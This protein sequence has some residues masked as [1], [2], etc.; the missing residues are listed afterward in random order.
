MADSWRVV[1]GRKATSSVFTVHSKVSAS[2][3]HSR[4]RGT[5]ALVSVPRVSLR[6]DM[7][8]A[9]R[10]PG[11]SG[12]SSRRPDAVEAARSSKSYCRR[13]SPN[14][15]VAKVFAKVETHTTDVVVIGG[16]IG[17][18]CAGALCALYG[19]KVTVV[20][21]HS[22]AGGAAHSWKRNGYTFESGPSLYSG[23]SKWPTTNPCGQVLHA[24]DEPLTCVEYNTWMVHVPEGSFLTEVG[25][26]QFVDVLREYVADVDGANAADEW[27]RL[28]ELMKPLAKASSALPPS[29]VRTDLGAVVTLARFVPG[30]LAAAPVLP[31]IMA[32]YSKFMEKNDIRHPF[33]KNWMEVLCFL[34]SGAPASGTLAAEIGYMFDDWYKPNST[35]EFPVGGSEAIV[36]ALTR[37]LR[38][39]G[40]RLEVN[41]HVAGINFDDAT[42]RATGV[43][44]KDG[45]V[46][47]AT[48]SVISNCTVWDTLKILPPNAMEECRADGSGKKWVDDVHETKMCAS[49]MHLHL[50]IDATG[51]PPDLEIHHI[52]V[53]DWA[54]GVTAEQNMV[55]V[56]IASVL[57]PTLA[58]TGKHVIHA[59]TPGNEPVELWQGLERGSDEYEKLKDTRSQILWRAVEKAIP[60]VRVRVE[61]QYVGSPLTQ[62]RWQ[63]RHKGTYGGTGWITPD[64]DTIPI[65]TAATPMAGLLVVGDSNFPGPG[66][67]S[68]AAHGW[69]AAHELVPF[70]KQCAM[71]DKVAP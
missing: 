20:E 47:T 6:D 31:E 25:N 13:A 61:C 38:K 10:A 21:S 2:P 9:M 19:K 17:G 48:E 18:L 66:V 49:F 30:L 60:D 14:R 26:D 33:V 65:T 59:Y 52:Y 46:I 39:N 63:R 54:R 8:V 3:P 51:L 34:L 5:P 50:G 45:T 29:A 68:V 27:L 7:P 23:M 70:W 71:L 42:K 35:L 44:L 12:L 64:S 28:K 22:V 41:S 37:G 58:P 69:S 36:D 15:R 67:P 43:T 1:S 40:G 4:R 62:Q 53:E 24:L 56:S 11:F 55:L 57:D 16:G 32:P